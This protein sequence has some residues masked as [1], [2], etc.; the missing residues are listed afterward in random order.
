LILAPLGPGQRRQRSRR[1]FS[2][3]IRYK[4]ALVGGIPIT[5]A[6][7]I[8]IAACGA[9]ARATRRTTWPGFFG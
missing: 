8:A 1:R 5:I 9:L 7:T 4:I 3:R 6:A 2:R